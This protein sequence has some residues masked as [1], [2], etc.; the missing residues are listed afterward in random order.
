[1]ALSILLMADAPGVTAAKSRRWRH[2]AGHVLQRFGIVAGNVGRNVMKYT[3]DPVA[4]IVESATPQLRRGA[5]R[6][7][8]HE[9]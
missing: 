5:G 3:I 1:M 4:G 9:N 8:N 6:S 7:Q 2:G